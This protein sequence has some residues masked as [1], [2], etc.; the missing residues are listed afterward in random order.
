MTTTSNSSKRSARERAEMEMNWYEVTL[1][2]THA[3][4]GEKLK[5]R[6]QRIEAR[7]RREAMQ[8]A[9]DTAPEVRWLEQRQR[10]DD[11]FEEVCFRLSSVMVERIVE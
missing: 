6:P 9:Q 8:K 1:I 5:Q 3:S 10:N 11:V 2:Y 4:T 7:T